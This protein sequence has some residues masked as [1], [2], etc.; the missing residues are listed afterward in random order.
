MASSAAAKLRKKNCFKPFSCEGWNTDGE[1]LTLRALTPKERDVLYALSDESREKLPDN[2]T[3][4]QQRA[5]VDAATKMSLT[6][7][8]MYLGDSAGNRIYEASDED[9]ADIKANIPELVILRVCEQ[10]RDYNA[11]V[12]KKN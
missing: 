9:F 5:Y 6:F 2:P 12:T 3:K 1:Q 7:F 4:E 11:D 10:G 8:S